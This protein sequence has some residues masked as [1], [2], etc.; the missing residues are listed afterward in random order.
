MNP[1]RRAPIDDDLLARLGDLHDRN[2]LQGHASEADVGVDDAAGSDERA[3]VHQTVHHFVEG[4]ARRAATDDVL[5]IA[6]RTVDSPFGSLLVAVTSRGV[7]RLAFDREDHAKVLDALAATVSPRILPTHARTDAVAREL[8][9]YFSG[10]RRAFALPVDLR[11]VN[12]FRRDV[13]TALGSI[14]YGTTQ[15]YGNLAAALKN[16]NAVR[17]VGTACAQN[18]VP[19]IVPC[20]RVVRSDGSIGNY[21]GGSDMKAALLKMES[22]AAN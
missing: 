6:V 9:E 10:R 12:G 8:D 5:D 20:H 18:P 2:A 17:A 14:P 22:A 21:R 19:V 16:P 3:T 7:V 1:K 4:L 13:V 11:L 15:S